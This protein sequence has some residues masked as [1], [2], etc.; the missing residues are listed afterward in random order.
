MPVSDVTLTLLQANSGASALLA[1]PT[2]DLGIN[3]DVS[4]ATVV[5]MD[6]SAYS[7]RATTNAVEPDATFDWDRD[8]SAGG[9]LANLQQ[10]VSTEDLDCVVAVDTDDLSFSDGSVNPTIA[11]DTYNGRR[12]SVS[13][14]TGG[15]PQE[16]FV[17]LDVRC[18]CDG[19]LS[20]YLFCA[21]LLIMN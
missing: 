12:V 19:I 16:E 14:Q 10:T 7:F 6:G 21:L 11:F 18:K 4:A 8:S 13:A 3:Q 2:T 9:F 5:V 1:N 17:T 20:E 15:N